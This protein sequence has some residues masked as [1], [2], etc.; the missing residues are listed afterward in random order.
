MKSIFK[1]LIAAFLAL[2]VLG[3]G[4]YAGY[5]IFAPQQ[6][7]T[8]VTAQ[9][10]LTALRD[11]GFLV[12]QTYVFDEPVTITKKSGSAL[13]NFFFGQTITARGAMEANLGIDLGKVSTS[14]IQIQADKI[15]VTVPKAQLFNV[16]LIGPLDVQNTQGILKR[17]LENDNG[18]NEA[19]AELARVA[20]E[21]ATKPEFVD[22]ATE[23]A[24][25]EIARLVGYIAQ[26]KTIEVNIK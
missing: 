5:R 1:I 13:S 10:I 24:K 11:R 17:L 4:I 14:D 15:V 18:Y 21:A 9:V 23:S 8:Q 7:K 3:L 25:T 26:G 19:Q 16:R 6:N 12:T 22:R 20:E 2:V